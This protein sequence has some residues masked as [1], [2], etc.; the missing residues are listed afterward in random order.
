MYKTDILYPNLEAELARA[1]IDKKEIAK[2][3]GKSKNTIYSRLNGKTELTL[4]E[5]RIIKA[6]LERRTGRVLQFTR[7]FN[8]ND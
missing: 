8:I 4:S 6:Y 7:L 1:G 2:V 5:A 3:I